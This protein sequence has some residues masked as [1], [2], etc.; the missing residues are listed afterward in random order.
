MVYLFLSDNS[1]LASSRL[2]EMQPSMKASILSFRSP[3]ALKLVVNSDPE[4]SK[5]VL[6]SVSG[7]NLSIMAESSA[8]GKCANSISSFLFMVRLF[9]G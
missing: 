7:P 1:L 6:G 2:P 9:I 5:C 8:S 4:K 3:T